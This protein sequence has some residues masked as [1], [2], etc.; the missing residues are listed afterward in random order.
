MM[1]SYVVTGGARGIGRAIAERLAREGH[2]VVVDV[3]AEAH[4]VAA[5]EVTGHSLVVW[6]TSYARSYGRDQRRDARD[7]LLAHGFGALFDDGCAAT[8]LPSESPSAVARTNGDEKSLHGTM[9]APGIE[10]GTS[11]V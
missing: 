8:A 4:P 6:A 11:R 2:V 9:G 5:A 1:C 10:P 3:D 7:R